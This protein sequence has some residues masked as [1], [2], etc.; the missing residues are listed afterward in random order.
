MFVYQIL[1]IL[2]S[3]S[4]HSSNR[5]I[6]HI[7][8]ANNSN[9]EAIA[10][11]IPEIIGYKFLL[12]SDLSPDNSERS[13]FWDQV[14]SIKSTATDRKFIFPLFCSKF[15]AVA[16]CE[17]YSCTVRNCSDGKIS[18]EELKIGNKCDIPFNSSLKLYEPELIFPTG[19]AQHTDKTK[20]A[21]GVPT[22]SKK[23][24]SFD[25]LAFLNIL[26]PSLINSITEVEKSEFIYTVFVGIDARDEYYDYQTHE[27]KFQ[28]FLCF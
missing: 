8:F 1:S 12:Y 17:D 5:D 15:H 22:T 18:Y 28:F 24:N 13:M 16:L 14:F 23:S 10:D 4:I 11:R 6:A 3:I 9:F 2:S 21:I 25:E 19:K 7:L 26:L 27:T 20:I